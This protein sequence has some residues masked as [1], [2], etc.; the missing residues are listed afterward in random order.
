MSGKTKRQSRA[1]KFLQARQ[2]AILLQRFQQ[3]RSGQKIQILNLRMWSRIPIH[4]TNLPMMA[5]TLAER[6]KIGA[7]MVGSF[8][9][10]SLAR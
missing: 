1:I 4:S 6:C 10:K 7:G 8:L 5:A 3:K 9:L 2:I